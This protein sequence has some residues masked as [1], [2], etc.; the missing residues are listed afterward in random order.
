MAIAFLLAYV[1]NFSKMKQ[2]NNPDTFC[3]QENL[4]VQTLVKAFHEFI[5][6]DALDNSN[7]E[8]KLSN[9]IKA[10]RLL[11]PEE[12]KQFASAIREERSIT[13]AYESGMKDAQA[14]AMQYI[15]K[16]NSEGRL[17]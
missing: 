3:P 17:S 11:F 9:K 4:Y 8:L 15:N 16:G 5:C 13:M 2:N 6:D 14:L 7:S 10:V 12:R 1:K